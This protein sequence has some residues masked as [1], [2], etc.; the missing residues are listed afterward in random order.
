MRDQG[1]NVGHFRTALF[2]IAP[3]SHPSLSPRHGKAVKFFFDCALD[4]YGAA[5]DVH[6][7]IYADIEKKAKYIIEHRDRNYPFQLDS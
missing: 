3:C 4:K 2:P 6:Q 1:P 5:K 7:N